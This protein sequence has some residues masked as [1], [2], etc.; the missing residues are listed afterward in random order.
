MILKLTR[1]SLMKAGL[2]CLIVFLSLSSPRSQDQDV[3]I[4]LIE[5]FGYAGFDV[6]S[7]QAA[8]PIHEGGVIASAELPGLKNR[9]SQS[10]RKKLGREVTGLSMV[11][12]E[13]HGHWM[14]FI[15]LPGRTWQSFNYRPAPKG[16]VRLPKEIIELY[17][18]TMRLNLEASQKQPEEDRSKG[19]ALAAY[20]P[21]REVQL[22]IREAALKHEPVV[23]AVLKN[24]ADVNSRRA[25]AYTLGY[26]RPSRRQISD[27]TTASR[28]PDDT[29][30]N[31]AVRALA[32][33][34]ASSNVRA[35]QIPTAGFMQML[36]SGSWTDRNKALMVL[37]IL[38]GRRQPGLLRELKRQSLEV[39]VEMARWR[40]PG[41]ALDA[42][43]IL[44]RIAAIEETDLLKFAHDNPEEIIRLVKALQNE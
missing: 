21:L 42:R 18:T 14:I 3:V 19:Y 39:L 20:L 15:G 22:R 11:C 43:M 5:F 29:V 9:I 6:N 27:L 16:A 32:V 12:C 10:V 13:K 2:V 28:D 35:A 38:S 24:S 17:E 44:G 34:A 26:A 37:G 36:K 40:N 8:L 4:G 7:I 23:R 25:A 30:R 41:H 31:N 33:I 1:P